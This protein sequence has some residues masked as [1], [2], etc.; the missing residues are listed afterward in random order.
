MLAGETPNIFDPALAG[1][2]LFD[3]GVYPLSAI[4]HLFGAPTSVTGSTVTIATGA[5][6]A[7]AAV[8]TAIAG[9]TKAVETEAVGGA[10]TGGSMFPVDALPSWLKPLQVISPTYW[11]LGG[12]LDVI[13]GATAGDVAWRAG[14]T[15]VIALALYAFGVWRLSYE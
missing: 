6:G 13:G 1:G 7:G 15:L 8:L 5:D 11:T 12:F 3:L 9:G 2:A 4:V 14:I 10:A